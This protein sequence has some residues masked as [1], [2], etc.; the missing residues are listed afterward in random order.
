MITEHLLFYYIA[1]IL[2]VSI[3]GLAVLFGFIR[4]STLTKEQKWFHTFLAFTFCTEILTNIMIEIS[5]ENMLVL[6][7]YLTGE[8]FLLTG[9]FIIGLKLPHWI[10]IVTGLISGGIFVET[11]I[12]WLLG[13]DIVSGYSTIVS[14]TI[15]I[16]LTGFYLIKALKNFD[17]GKQNKFLKVYAC[18]F[19]YY[20]VSLFLFISL[21]Q[22]SN[23]D[24]INASIAWGINNILS[25]VL[26]GISLLTFIKLK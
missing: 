13:Q 1:T 17:Y 11:F 4:F 23:L 12:L 10:F 21:N 7:F 19:L 6:P 18:L 14:N 25:S 16:S 8:F 20:S 9:I 22:L 15:I 5:Y 26:Y 2:A 3:L 24:I